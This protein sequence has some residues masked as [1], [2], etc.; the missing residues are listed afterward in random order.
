MKTNLKLILLFLIG[1]MGVTSCDVD[2]TIDPN[3]AS[4]GSVTNNPSPNQINFLGIGVQSTIRDGIRDFYL[5]SGTVGREVILSASTDNRYFNELLGTEAANFN[6]ANDPNGIFNAYYFNFSQ[7]RHRAE[8]FTQSAETSKTLTTEQKAGIKGFARTVQAYLA[9]NLLNMQYNNGIRETFQDLTSPG[10]QL[11]PGPFG[12]YQSGLTLIK[13]Y[14]DEGATLLAGGG[15]NFAFPMT[16]GWAG[17]DTPA[18]F[19]KFNKA[20]TARVALYQKDWDG[21]LTALSGSFINASGAGVLST[22]PVFTFATT[23]GDQL[24][25]LWAKPSDTGAPYVAYDEFVTDAETNSVT[26]LK[27]IRVSKVGLRDAARQ[28]GQALLSK[29]DVRMYATNVSSV[30]IIRNE[31]LIL[32]SAEAKIQKNDLAGGIA[33]LDKVRVDNGL[34]P[35]GIAKPTITSQAQL[36]DEL[37]NQRRY[38]LFFEGHRWF[39]VRRYNK[40]SILPLQGAVNGNNY[41]VFPQ[42][43]KPDAEV[44]WDLANPN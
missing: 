44:Q 18:S 14:L 31:E 35:M 24:N 16:K 17:F 40:V 29:Y 7:G 43:N 36:L 15:S 33:A 30:S 41:A 12:T 37:L 38:S 21:V 42:F 2:N 23:P 26:G 22:G 34:Q 28:S 27:D 11:K 32:M 19:L 20:I 13:G 5:N 6:G 8:V 4:L 25:T 39:D 9:L 10:D 1:V 3:R